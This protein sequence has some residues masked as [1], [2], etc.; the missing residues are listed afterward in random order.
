MTPRY[1][2]QGRERGSGP[3]PGTLA[4][5]LS[6]VRSGP[7]PPVVDARHPPRRMLQRTGLRKRG[8]ERITGPGSR[9]E[10]VGPAHNSVSP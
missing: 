5:A 1:V 10:R 6:S 3:V 8:A 7:G 9:T 4:R 2:E